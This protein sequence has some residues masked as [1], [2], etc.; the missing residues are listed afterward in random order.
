MSKAFKGKPLELGVDADSDASSKWEEVEARCWAAGCK[1]ISTWAS[2]WSPSLHLDMPAK[3]KDE[4]RRLF[5]PLLSTAR[6]KKDDHRA[7]R[8]FLTLVPDVDSLDEA[9]ST[10]LLEMIDQDKVDLA[11][12]LLEQGAK[13]N[14]VRTEEVRFGKEEVKKVHEVPLQ[15]AVRK[16]SL[17]MTELLLQKGASIDTIQTTGASTLLLAVEGAAKARTKQSLRL[18][19]LLLD[20]GCNVNECGTIGR[21][22]LHVAVNASLGDSE[23]GVDLESLLLN[24]GADV[25]ALDCRGRTPLHYAFVKMGR[26]KDRTRCDPIQ[27]VSSLAEA[28][29]VDLI[30][31]TDNFG[32]TALH[33]A[34]L[35]GATVSALLLL[36]KGS[37]CIEAKDSLGNTPLSLSVLGKHDAC[38]M[39]LLQRGA[40]VDVTIKEEDLAAGEKCRRLW[41]HLAQHWGKKGRPR[42]VHIADSRGV[43]FQQFGYSLSLNLLRVA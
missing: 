15:R 25:G 37:K 9:G 39:M 10:P 27:V 26:H 7:F 8:V 20:N 33:Y 11:R 17:A 40:C 41:R 2:E 35:R 1:I 24:R 16:G 29:T 21:T 43:H 31:H 30:D 18:V 22:A 42:K 14:R 38:S 32:N 19:S 23:S 34:G 28:M 13:V 5:L 36:Q 12:L 3:K 6:F 4:S